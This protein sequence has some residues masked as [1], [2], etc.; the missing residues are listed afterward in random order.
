MNHVDCQELIKAFG[1]YPV[2][3]FAVVDGAHFDD[4]ATELSSIQ[5]SGEPLFLSDMG[6]GAELSGPWLVTLPDWEAANRVLTLVGDLPAVAF[7]SWPDGKRALYN[8]LR[9]LNM[10]EIPIDDY[11]PDFPDWDRVIFRHADPNVMANTLSVLEEDQFAKVLGNAA[12]LVMYAPDFGDLQEAPR[13]EHK[14]EIP[15]GPLRFEIEQ[16][17]AMDQNNW[18]QLKTRALRELP[19]KLNRPQNEAREQVADAFERAKDYG[20]ETKDQIWTFIGFDITY[21]QRFELTNKYS[22]VHLD[23]TDEQSTP[24]IR[25]HDAGKEIEAIMKGWVQNV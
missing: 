20:L 14:V 16:I 9:R 22:S 5:L 10:V 24:D 4:I 15:K 18:I 19:V 17:E 8:H 11:N 3:R 23:L 2:A 1:R 13:L 12:A 7:W 21:G 25:I 6:D